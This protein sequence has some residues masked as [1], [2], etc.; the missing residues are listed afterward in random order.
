VNT[1]LFLSILP[2]CYLYTSDKTALRLADPT[3]QYVVSAS[4]F[5]RT[6]FPCWL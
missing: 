5:I 3:K 4:S 2:L 1:S 6:P